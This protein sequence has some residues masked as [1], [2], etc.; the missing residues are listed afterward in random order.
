MFRMNRL[1]MASIAAAVVGA[2]ALGAAWM[3]P[4]GRSMAADSPPSERAANRSLYHRPTSVPYPESDPYTPE[5]EWLGA[6]LF[7]DTALSGPGN[8]SC[9]SCHMA[10]KAWSDGQARAVGNTGAKLPIRSPTILD[11]AWGDVMGW[12]GKFADVEAVAFA[13]IGN[14]KNM[15]SSA[16]AVLAKL[17]ADPSYV[18]AFRTAFPNDG[19]TRWNTES[20]LATYERGIV[21]GEAPFDR[22]I[23]GDE[24]AITEEAKRGFDVFNGKA[25]CSS[26]HAGWNFTDGSFHDIG[27]AT[28]TD[29]GR[30]RLMPKSTKLQYAFKVPTLRDTAVQAHWMHD[31]ALSSLADVVDL[32]D[33]GGIERPS[34]ASPIRPLGLTDGEKHDLLAFLETLTADTDAKGKAPAAGR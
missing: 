23:M 5:K 10:D 20:A 15:G 22:W 4:S 32:Y 25:S 6:R 19:V 26:C 34:R 13:A 7:K 31:G 30:G 12:D 9:A 18:A 3:A 1:N 27:S 17:A 2:V 11:V 8:I 28:G 21:A 33:R 24:K 14:P 29:I 16:D